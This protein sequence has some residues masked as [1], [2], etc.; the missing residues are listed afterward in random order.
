MSFFKRGND[1]NSN[2]PVKKAKI[3]LR[4]IACIGLVYIAIGMLGPRQQQDLD[5]H[6]VLSF[7]IPVVFLGFAVYF[8]YVELKQYIKDWRED[9]RAEQEAAQAAKE[10]A[11][12]AKLLEASS[13]DDGDDNGDGGDYEDDDSDDEYEEYDDE[14]DEGEEAVEDEQAESEKPPDS[15]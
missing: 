14:A 4:L 11:E 8:G 13:D 1:S 9:R 7:G 15:K 5:L 10:E 6:P 3:N 2:Q 12:A